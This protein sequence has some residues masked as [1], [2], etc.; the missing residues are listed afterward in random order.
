MAESA[1]IASAYVEACLD[2]LNAL[3]PGNVHAFAGGHR[4]IT[5]DFETSARLSAPHVARTG[6]R[7]GARIRAA[8]EATV[9]AVGSN[10]NLGIV[11]L[12]APIAAAAERAGDLHAALAGVLRGLDRGDAVDVFAAIR[13][14]A[15]AGLGR[16]AVH[17]VQG[18]PQASLREIMASASSRDRIARAYVHDFDD[19]FAIGLPALMQARR[20][21]VDDSWC[22]TAVYLAFLT[23]FPDT[24]I[25][26][27]FGLDRA[28]EIRLGA[29]TLTRGL[30]LGLV[31]VEPL[32]A[33]DAALKSDG[34]N[35]G[36][37]AD[38]TVATLFVDK[39]AGAPVS[40]A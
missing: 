16:A 14:A 28:A 23:T 10:T 18:E 35:P 9:E 17:D 12:C 11:L 22:A 25:V 34:I 20:R 38:F 36:T 13:R 2:E 31:A 5:A 4:M 24:H 27:K 7:V 30:D 15:P 21:G 40:S 39:L 8:V 26:R 1:A 32:L 33:L 3:K 6:A 37:S 19:L 29:Q